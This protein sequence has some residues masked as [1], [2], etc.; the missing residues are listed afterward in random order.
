MLIVVA[1]STAGGGFPQRKSSTDLYRSVRYKQFSR[2]K[3]STQIS[4]QLS[5][6]VIAGGENLLSS[7]ELET[8]K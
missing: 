5:I 7:T 4:T 6:A 2:Q 3:S 1:G 8:E